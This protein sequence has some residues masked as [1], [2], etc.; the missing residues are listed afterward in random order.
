MPGSLRRFPRKEQAVRADPASR[1]CVRR[2]EG[3]PVA[4]GDRG[5]SAAARG[6]T[7]DTGP[8]PT[9]PVSARWKEWC[10]RREHPGGPLLRLISPAQTHA[11]GALPL[12][13]GTH[14]VSSCRGCDDEPPYG[15]RAVLGVRQRKACRIRCCISGW[16]RPNPLP[17]AFGYRR[18]GAF[19]A[20]TTARPP[21]GR[22]RLPP[23]TPCVIVQRSTGAISRRG[24]ECA[25]SPARRPG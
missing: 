9:P 14:L 6:E 15:R 3:P 12:E 13:D 22:L 4:G 16:T 18:D 25:D 19:A 23:A 17:S 24:D 5:R 20:V 2:H 7:I 1:G 21:P 11:G 10:P 8:R